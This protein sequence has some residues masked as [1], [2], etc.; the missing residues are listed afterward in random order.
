MIINTWE[1]PQFI[2]LNTLVPRPPLYSFDSIEEALDKEQSPYIHSLNGSWDFKLFNSPKEAHLNVSAWDQIKVPSCW[3]REGFDD[4]P[5]YT[6]VQMPFDE[7]YPK[8]PKHNPTGVY[9][10]KFENVWPDRR[11]IIHFAGVETMFHLYVNDCEV[12]MS[13]GSRTPVEFDLSEYL[14]EGENDLYVKVIRW[15]DGSYIE[16][17]DHWRMAGIFRDVY[18]YSSQDK[19]IED[20]FA[21]AELKEDLKGGELTC[22]LRLA[23]RY[24]DLEPHRITIK[25]FDNEKNEIWTGKKHCRVSPYQSHQASKNEGGE[26]IYHHIL[27]LKTELDDIIAWNAEKPYQ[28]TVIASLYDQNDYLFDCVK[29]R[30]GFKRIEI[31]KQEL[32]INGQAVLIKGVNRHEHDEYTGKVVS[33][34]SMI[35]DIKLLKQFNFNAVRNA[36][37][38]QA[39]LWY[40]LCNE[41]GLYVI[42][43]ANLESHNDYDT[44]CRDPVYAPAFLNR[45]M[46]MFHSHKN[47]ACIFQWSTGNESGYGPNHDMA[48]GYLKSVDSSRIIQCEG[49]I[50]QEWN[51][52]GPVN[53]AH[54]GMVSDT[55]SPM[56]PEIEAMH[57]WAKDRHNDPRPYMPCEYNHAM[58]NS[59]G[60]LKDYWKAFREVHGLQGGFIWDWLDQGLAEYDVDGEKYWTYGGDYGE[61]IHDF[62]FCI[63]GMVLPDRTPKP[64]MYEFKKCAEPIL[65]EQINRTQYRISNDQYFSDFTNVSMRWTV[66]IDGV[67]TQESCGISLI[68]EAQK[69]LDY[70]VNLDDI[71]V[72]ENTTVSVNFYFT[73]IKES[74]WHEAGQEITFSQFLIKADKYLSS[75]IKDASHYLK[76]K[77][78]KIFCGER[79][80]LVPEINIFRACTDNDTIRGWTGQDHKI[81]TQW[82]AAELDKL[83]L[84][85]ENFYDEDGKII[86]DR[87]YL[88][89]DKQISH[90]MTLDSSLEF[91]H[92][93][94]I[95][96][97][98]PSLARIGV[99]YKIPKAYEQVQWL[100]LGPHENYRDR[101]YGARYSLYSNKVND[102]YVPYILPQAHGNRSK[103]NKLSLSDGHNSFDFRGE[104]EFSLSPWSDEE[105]ISSFH[106]CDLKHKGKQDFYWLHLDLMHRGVGSGSCGPDTRSEYC[107]PAKNYIFRYFIETLI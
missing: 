63:N 13:K 40:E 25:L 48:I 41:Y 35:K 71:S 98:L 94:T 77:N 99:K 61:K 12:G 26:V 107:I 1:N 42:D 60:S 85:S 95:P 46:R 81:G 33:R 43:E 24:R 53:N 80:I 102:H 36:H 37:Y 87:I 39:E 17:Q 68:I 58:G 45:V 16:D 75:D 15:S 50:H 65:V 69:F 20:L 101:D 84:Q 67:I 8:V 96:E 47:H 105:L 79:E 18:L 55:F 54:H 57:E 31:K 9:H 38:P 88:A 21:Q 92:S 91:C 86:I 29:T 82:L 10:R 14:Q 34:E 104:F 11:T 7:S 32:L 62:D 19:Y 49:A 59:N 52:T 4:L 5:I 103:V 6:N 22:D 66:E 28:Y 44:I 106:T 56:Y 83:K 70:T 97:D 30:I 23:S 3:T 72:P 78:N 100:G 73:Y 74:S 2:S 93:F 90:K 51:Q 27:K 89:K 76:L 64:G